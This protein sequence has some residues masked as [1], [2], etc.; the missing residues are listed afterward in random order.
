MRKCPMRLLLVDQHFSMPSMGPT[1]C[2]PRCH[3]PAISRLPQATLVQEN[4]CCIWAACASGDESGTILEPSRAFL[5]WRRSPKPESCPTLQ[6]EVPGNYGR[7]EASDS[8]DAPRLP[9]CRQ[10]HSSGQA[11]CAGEVGQIVHYLGR[12]ASAYFQ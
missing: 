7:Q 11:I 4:G 10:T 3:R 2:T 1:N 6:F 9:V 5:A 12:V 8:Q